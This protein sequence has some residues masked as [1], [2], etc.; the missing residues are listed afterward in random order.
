MVLFNLV[1]YNTVFI[2]LFYQNNSRLAVGVWW[3][4]NALLFNVPPTNNPHTQPIFE[5]NVISIC[6]FPP[7]FIT[8]T[9]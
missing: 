3:W 1:Y 8:I 4:V 5:Y 7:F 6:L 2:L 9:F